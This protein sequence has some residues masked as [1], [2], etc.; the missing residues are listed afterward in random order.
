[1]PSTGKK[2]NS[3]SPLERLQALFLEAVEEIGEAAAID[4]LGEPLS[5]FIAYTADGGVSLNFDQEK[6]GVPDTVKAINA[7]KAALGK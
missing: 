7:F 1:M 2:G 3:Q 6:P 5:F 4:C